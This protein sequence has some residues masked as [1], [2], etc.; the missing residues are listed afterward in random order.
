ME[1]G[2]G[3]MLL[4]NLFTREI[5]IL[6]WVFFNLTLSVFDVT[7]LI[8]HLPFYAAMFLLILWKPSEHS[9]ELWRAGLQDTLLPLHQATSAGIPGRA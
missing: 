4:F 1:L 6:A 7:E 3:L 2:I 8:N 9:Q 5:S